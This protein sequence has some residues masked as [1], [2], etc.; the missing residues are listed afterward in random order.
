MK[1]NNKKRKVN[2]K[3]FL[4]SFIIVIFVA[5]LGSLFTSQGTSSSW[6]EQV[7]PSITPPSYVF[8]IA[9]TILFVLIALALYITWVS[10]SEDEKPRIVWLYGFNFI[11]NII[12]SLL[13]FTLR[14]PLFAFIEILAMEISIVF[15]FILSYR[16]NKAAAWM[17]LPYLLWVAFASVLTGMVAFM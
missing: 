5:Y 3:A 11:L 6:Y 15:M 16:I 14:N 1:S 12:W 10:A 13:F 4:L 17:L 8:P 2:W 9:W 7:K